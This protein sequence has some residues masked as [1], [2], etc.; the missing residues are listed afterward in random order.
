M[1]VVP[2]RDEPLPRLRALQAA[3]ADMGG[4]SLL[5]VV[6]N[7]PT[8]EVP[9]EADRSVAAAASERAP[10]GPARTGWCSRHKSVDMMWIERCGDAGIP[11]REGVGRARKIGGD[12]ALRLWREGLVREPWIHF[13]DADARPSPALR[14]MAAWSR[15]AAVV[16]PFVHGTHD[17]PD[18]ARAHLQ[19]EIWMR[20]WVRGLESAGSPF[21]YHTIGSC[22]SVAARAYGDARGVPAR[23]AGEDFHLLNKLAKLGGIARP[24]VAPVEIEARRSSRVPFGTGP[25]VSRL[26]ADVSTWK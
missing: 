21:A 26:A 12:V 25:A 11:A 7:G 1:M 2:C 13:T 9:T 8:G 23:P 3:L 18:V 6:V 20:W 19:H 15:G 5:I 14:D 17:E 4:S 24:H 16:W 10:L 22:I